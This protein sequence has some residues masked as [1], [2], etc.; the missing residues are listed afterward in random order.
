V[1]T[2][3]DGLWDA[4]ELVEGTDPFE[5]DTDGDGFSDGVEVYFR[6]L[7]APFDPDQVADPDGG[8]L[9]PGCPTPL[10]AAD[11]DCDGLLDCDEQIIGSNALL[12]DS[13]RDGIPDSIEWQEGLSPASDDLDEDPD[14]DGLVNRLEARLHMNP[15]AIDS[16]SLTL[17]GYRY[18]LEEMGPV[19]PAGRQCFQYVVDNVLLVDTAAEYWDGGQD[20]GVGVAVG[21]GLP[22]GGSLLLRGRGYNELYVA[23]EMVPNDDVRARPEVRAFHTT[24]V[25]YPVAGIKWP[26][27]GVISVA[28]EQMVD[29]CG[30]RDGGDDG[31][32][33]GGP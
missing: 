12:T 23:V 4:D 26:V 15:A 1:D 25:R 27:D 3:G 14:T 2:D 16:A 32:V 9:D 24:D 20:A 13:D 10:R 17:Q 6:A 8:G 19:D 21:A 28:P 7:G 29:R 30:P 11:N 22:D 31:G 5:K 33:D 18:F